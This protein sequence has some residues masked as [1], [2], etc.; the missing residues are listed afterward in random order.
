MGCLLVARGVTQRTSCRRQWAMS[1]IIL[2]GPCAPQL[3][4][5]IFQHAKHRGHVPGTSTARAGGRRQSRGWRHSQ[6]LVHW[7]K[8]STKMQVIALGFA[9][10]VQ[11][12]LSAVCSQTTCL[13]QKGCQRWGWAQHCPGSPGRC[14]SS[15]SGNLASRG[16]ITAQHQHPTSYKGWAREE[17]ST[18][19]ALGNQG[20]CTKTDAAKQLF[21]K[22]GKFKYFLSYGISIQHS[23][24]SFMVISYQPFTG[25]PNKNTLLHLLTS[26]PKLS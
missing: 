22:C 12:C 11:V 5:H 13:L 14:I 21:L 8:L 6:K 26:L 20:A 19:H 9:L 4:E 10:K 17:L 2:G 24:P 25:K 3:W 7:D 16:D 15:S 18:W 23:T 1:E